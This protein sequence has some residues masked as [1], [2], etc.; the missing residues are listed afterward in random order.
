MTFEDFK[1]LTRKTA[2]GI[3]DKA[4]DIAKNPKYDAYHRGLVSTVHKF[5]NNKTSGGAVK[6]ENMSNKKI[7]RR[8]TQ[9]SYWK[10]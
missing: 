5:F 9:A 2:S 10:I 8:I 1:D 7:S 4:F 3:C 6:H